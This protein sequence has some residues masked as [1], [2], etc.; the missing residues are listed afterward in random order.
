M[1]NN[2]LVQRI[3]ET[4]TKI[5][6][7]LTAT[8]ALERMEKLSTMSGLSYSTGYGQLNQPVPPY[9]R[10]F[11][12][13]WIYKI[14]RDSPLMNNAMRQKIWQTFREGMSEWKKE[15]TA[16]CPN[17]QEEFQG[18]DPFVKQLEDE[19]E[20]EMPEE[21]MGD[22][23][24]GGD[25]EMPA[26]GPDEPPSDEEKSLSKQGLGGGAMGEREPGGAEGPAGPGGGGPMGGGPMPGGMPGM[27]EDE[28][29]SD[30]VDLDEPVECP[31][32][33][34]EVVMSEPDPEIREKAQDFFDEANWRGKY[35]TES[36][37]PLE[38][39]DFSA[40]SQSFVDVLEE[41]A[42]DIQSFDDG[43]MLFEKS[44]VLDEEGYIVDFELENVKR[45]PPELM[46]WSIDD[47]T[48]E[49][50]GEFYVCPKCR[51]EAGNEPGNLGYIPEEEPGRC[52]ECGNVTYEA[53]AYATMT[54]AGQ[55]GEP[56]EFFIRGEFYHDSEY[57]RKRWY[58]YPPVLTLWEEARTV[59]QMDKWYSDAYE[60]RRAPRGA[61]LVNAAHDSELRQMN[62][63]QME[64][65]R[66]DPNYIP[67]FM[68]DNEEEGDPIKFVELLAEPAEMQHMEMR[69]WFMDRISAHFGVNAVLMSSSPEES[70]MSQSMEVE[71]SEKQAEHFRDV[72]NNFIDVF[73]AQIGTPG[74]T[75]E[76][77]QVKEDDPEQEAQLVGQH[78]NNAQK[79]IQMGIEAEWENDDRVDLKPGE[80]EMPAEGPGGMDEMG[81][82]GGV[83]GPR[84]P[85]PMPMDPG[86]GPLESGG[87]RQ[88]PAD[89]D[90]PAATPLK[91]VEGSGGDDRLEKIASMA[92]DAPEEGYDVE[93]N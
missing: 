20:E 76:L 3:G 49:P 85:E 74:W 18:Y 32:C 42:W 45:A 17:C 60:E 50:G 70:G 66:E 1:A 34:E 79:A 37:V 41:V 58:G 23:M 30:D 36:Y 13:L 68:N 89:E 31:E 62:R 46:R 72:L 78:L 92:F 86:E 12:P 65:M 59:E 84:G 27:G 82:E 51:A 29:D 19:Q 44:Y 9:Q 83:Q 25:E 64:M 91:A 4:I 53:Y 80:M 67:L 21:P 10:T 52:S 28:I 48:N 7:G 35:Q 11:S 87:E 93:R 75:R 16:K 26:G 40:I 38:P 81:M 43:W 88:G 5:G 69:E 8:G 6:G 47:D 54:P 55:G 77:L 24:P 61:L 15:Y 14:R 2:G 39:A 57:E 71:V 73:L 33:E 22:M 63:Q 90:R 56:D